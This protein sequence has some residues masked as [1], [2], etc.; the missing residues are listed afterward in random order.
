MKA[1]NEILDFIK[2][3][4]K[5]STIPLHEPFFG[6]NEKKYLIECIDSSFVS[7]VGPFVDRFE[8]NITEFSG[9]DY[10]VAILMVECT[11]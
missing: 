8:R 4:F 3:I 11:L 2:K 7:S 10:A 6:G 9:T 1:N 5:K